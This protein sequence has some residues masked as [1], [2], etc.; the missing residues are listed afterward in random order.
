M[1][2]LQFIEVDNKVED[3]IFACGIESINNYIRESYYPHIVQNAYTYSIMYKDIILGYYQ[4][5]FREIKLED[6]PEEI[7]DYST[8]I[9]NSKLS[10]VHIRFIAI[11]EKY[12]KNG[13][14][15][16]VL[17]TIIE[18]VRQLS[19]FWPIRVITIDAKLDLIGWYS[20]IGFNKMIHNTA[21]QDGTT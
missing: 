8:E 1:G 5:M 4:I 16:A 13:I 6:F 17:H 18:K 11:D 7:S 15:T 10:A 9:N 12:Q 21:G 19:I 3:A 20:E 2:K 14:G